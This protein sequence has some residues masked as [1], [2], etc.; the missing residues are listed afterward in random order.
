MDKMNVYEI[1]AWIGTLTT[2][3]NGYLATQNPE[4]L[5]FSKK[6][7]NL[8]VFILGLVSVISSHFMPK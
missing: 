5:P 1:V 3:I 2:L 4:N 6:T 8:L 7:L